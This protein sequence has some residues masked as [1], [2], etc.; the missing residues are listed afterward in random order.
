[1]HHHGDRLIGIKVGLAV[2]ARQ[3]QQR[4]LGLVR[5][6]LADQPPRRLGGEEDADAER[7]GPH[8]LQGVGDTVGPLVVALEH[9]AQHA[10][11]NLLTEAP[12]EVD[13][14]GEVAAEGDG[15]DLG[16]VGD[17]ERLEDA[18]GDAAEDLG[19]EERLDVLGREEDGREAGDEHEADHDGVAV[20]E[21][22]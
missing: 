22:F 13:V 21:A 2:Q 20:A 15:A 7:D 1:M 8:P 18:P 5:L 11:A 19:G 3:P 6:S 17:G 16:G 9:G 12:A 4:L 10:D 14:G